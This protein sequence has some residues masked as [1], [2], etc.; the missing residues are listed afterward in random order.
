MTIAEPNGS[1]G[2][3]EIEEKTRSKPGIVAVRRDDAACVQF[4]DDIFVPVAGLSEQLASRHE[5]AS[6]IFDR[7]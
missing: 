1:L 4:I 5:Q 6:M 2:A 3:I 7:R